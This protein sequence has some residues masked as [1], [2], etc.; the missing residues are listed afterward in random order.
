MRLTH[1]H[2]HGQA[3]TVERRLNDALLADIEN[4]KISLNR[5]PAFI[6][7]VSNFSNFLDLF[8]KTIRNMELGVPCVVLSRSNTTQHMYRWAVLLLEL[9]EKHNVPA[10][11]LTYASA[12][13]DGIKRIFA[14][15][16]KTCPMLI[17][18]SR[19]LAADVKSGHPNT[20]SSTGGPNTLVAGGSGVL[21][22]KIKEAIRISAMI[23][24][25]GQC[26]ALRHAVCVGAEDSAFASVFDDAATVTTSA[27]ALRTGEFAGVFVDAPE[28]PTPE[29]YTKVKGLNAHYKINDDKLPEDGVMEYWRKVFVDVTNLKEPMKAGSKSAGEL[30]S[31]LVR[32]QPITLAVNDDYELGRYLFEKTGQVVYTIGE[33][34]TPALSCQA[35]PQEG[36][37]FGEFPVRKDLSKFTKFPVLVPTPTAAYN[38]QYCQDYLKTASGE[39]VSMSMIAHVT[40]D[41]K[42]GYCVEILNYLEDSVGAKEGYGF[43]TTLWG[44]QTPPQ[45]GRRTVLKCEKGTV[46]DDIAAKCVVFGATNAKDMFVVQCEEE[47]LQRQLEGFGFATVAWGEEED[48][49]NVLGKD[50]YG[51]EEFPLAGQFCSLYLGVG[52]VK[53]TKTGDKKFLEVFQDSKKWLKM[54]I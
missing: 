34:D 10:G 32:N 44:L 54:A 5:S 9:M 7:C 12:D 25:S 41:V 49:Y 13:I 51:V 43:R 22:P 24:N 45:D 14:E 28:E 52:H 39:V 36:E 4:G 1:A 20:M 23:E 17:T 18:C 19:D 48:W 8:R 16:P 53:S 15:S 37:I 40:D 26:T 11:M 6:G 27:D 35:R 21:S 38:S 33:G 50:D 29:G 2:A 3:N 30:A 42:K 47:G 31:W 46:F